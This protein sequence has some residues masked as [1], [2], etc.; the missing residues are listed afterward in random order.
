MSQERS[1]EWL[2]GAVAV[3]AE[4]DKRIYGGVSVKPYTVISQAMNGEYLA[5]LAAAEA[6]EAGELKPT[7][8]EQLSAAVDAIYAKYGPR[9]DLFFADVKKAREAAQ[10]TAEEPKG[11][12][13]WLTDNHVRTKDGKLCCVEVRRPDTHGGMC[14]TWKVKDFDIQAEMDGC[15]VGEEIVLRYAELTDAEFTALGDFDGW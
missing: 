14:C 3:L 11:I 15:E 10:P 4:M 8:N 2:R 5:L 12:D 6:S 1:A 7:A 9:L 13:A